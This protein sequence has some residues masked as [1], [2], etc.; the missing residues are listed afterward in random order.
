MRP[1]IT[2]HFSKRSPPESTTT[3]RITVTIDL[4]NSLLSAA[5]QQLIKDL[6]GHFQPVPWTEITPAQLL[7]TDAKTLHAR[8]EQPAKGCRILVI[9]TGLPPAEIERLFL[10]DQISGL[11]PQESTPEL[12]EKALN[13]IA[14]GEMWIDNA[15]FRNLLEQKRMSPPPTAQP[16]L[17]RREQQIFDLL[18]QGCKNQEIAAQVFLSESTV[19]VHVSKIYRKYKVKRRA[20]LISKMLQQTDLSPDTQQ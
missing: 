16:L 13:R 8:H 3:T 5:L 20:Q 11:L 9:D 17:T 14:D 7:I 6:P 18:M 2:S 1:V 19:K 12:F 15:A 10:N 4:A